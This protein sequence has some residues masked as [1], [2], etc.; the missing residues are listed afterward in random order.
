MPGEKARK[1][2]KMSSRKR[3]VARGVTREAYD[4][5][6]DSKVIR[7]LARPCP[8]MVNFHLGFL[9]GLG[10]KLDLR[11][12]RYVLL[13]LNLI[14]AA[15]TIEIMTGWWMIENIKREVSRSEKF[16]INGWL[17]H[18]INAIETVSI[19]KADDFF[20]YTSLILFFYWVIIGVKVCKNYGAEK[21]LYGLLL[22][23]PALC[24]LALFEVYYSVVIL[25]IAEALSELDCNQLRPHL[26]YNNLAMLMDLRNFMVAEGVRIAAL[27]VTSAFVQFI[28]GLLPFFLSDL[29]FQRRL[30]MDDFLFNDLKRSDDIDPNNNEE[31]AEMANRRMASVK[32]PCAAKSLMLRLCRPEVREF[33]RRKQIVDAN[34]DMFNEEYFHSAATM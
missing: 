15:A 18:K 28:T 7:E 23:F 31:M 9:F 2:S 12:I 30:Y 5:T 25:H 8:N 21:D 19:A 10:S 24:V 20:A 6:I 33:H 17:E 32:Y 34:P 27:F 1:W 3:S 29:P 14:V 11:H 26:S 16:H 4:A 22:A 13:T